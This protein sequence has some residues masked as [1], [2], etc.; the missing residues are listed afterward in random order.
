MRCR[1]IDQSRERQPRQHGTENA[2]ARQQ[3]AAHAAVGLFRRRFSCAC[4][5]NGRALPS[6]FL[7]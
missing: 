3:T 5:F 2:R 1:I 7:C 4:W 6:A